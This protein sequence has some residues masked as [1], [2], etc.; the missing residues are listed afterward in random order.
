MRILEQMLLV[1]RE[2]FNKAST[3]A[4]QSITSAI[5]SRQLA[6]FTCM[7]TRLVNFLLPAIG[8]K[9]GEAK[10][11]QNAGNTLT[12]PLCGTIRS[13]IVSIFELGVREITVIG[14]LDCGMAKLDAHGLFEKMISRGI[15]R[16]AIKMVKKELEDWVDH[17]H[18]PVENVIEVVGKIRDNPLI[19]RD[20]PVHGLLFDP[21]SGQVDVLVDGYAAAAFDDV[22][23][24][25]Q[26]NL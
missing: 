21:Q 3:E 16:E 23:V 6:I 17:F 20:V 1:N 13:L 22:A 14:H 26:G 4:V 10:V 8:I 24:D 18:D 25:A 5:P 11:I 12:G 15:S 7:D 19:P 2:F 9:R